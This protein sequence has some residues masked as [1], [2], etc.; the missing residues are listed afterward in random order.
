LPPGPAGLVYDLGCGTVRVAW[1]LAPP[2]EPGVVGIDLD[3]AISDL[4][5]INPARLRQRRSPIE[6][7]CEDATLSN[8]CDG[9]IYFMYNPFGGKSMKSVLDKIELSLKTKSRRVRIV[10]YNSVFEEL[11]VSCKWLHR[12]HE[13]KTL[14]RRR[15]TL[16]SSRGAE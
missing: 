4:P 2:P 13:F 9:T 1:L 14:T 12:V 8:L 7:R 5:P 3:R 15:V 10:Y 16:W 6:I 11:F